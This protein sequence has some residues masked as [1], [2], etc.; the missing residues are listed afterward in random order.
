MNTAPKNGELVRGFFQDHIGL[1]EG[2]LVAYD[3][4]LGWMGVKDGKKTPL[5]AELAGWLPV[6]SGRKK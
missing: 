6:A 2:P 4:N 5:A 3:A 1:Y